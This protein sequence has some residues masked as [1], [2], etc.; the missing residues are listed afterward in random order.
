MIAAD[1]VAAACYSIAGAAW[2]VV[3]INIAVQASLS[4]SSRRR[5]RQQR[6][7]DAQTE[8]Y[9][10]VAG[11]LATGR[12]STMASLAR[13]YAIR[14]NDWRGYTTTATYV[15]E[16]TSIT[17]ADLN[18]AYDVMG[19]PPRQPPVAPPEIQARIDELMA[20]QMRQQEA[21]EKALARET[22]L[23]ID[24]AEPFWAWHDRKEK[25]NEQHERS[26]AATG[27]A[28]SEAKRSREALGTVRYV[29]SA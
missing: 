7:R 9:V 27:R 13:Q 29:A 16:G 22:Q 18:R 24:L 15:D 26:A 3:T 6:S 4:R 20:A 23:K 28:V 8:R 11:G 1:T 10:A 5:S 17:A 2:M 14:P 21:R 12:T 19:G 25:E